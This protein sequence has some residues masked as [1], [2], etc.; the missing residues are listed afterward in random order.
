MVK[1]AL[2]TDA[3]R[4]PDKQV[5]EDA[6]AQRE[7]PFGHLV[8]VCDGMG[9]HIGGREA[10]TA[11]VEAIV[12]TFEQA[13]D[14]EHG[15]VLLDRAISSANDAV[16]RIGVGFAESERPGST[17]VA[18]LV[19]D[20]GTEVA[21]VGD[22]RCYRVHQQGVVQLTRD[23]SMVQQLVNLG[24]LTPEQAKHHPDAN[25]ITRALGTD[26]AERAEL[27]PSPIE[28][29]AGDTFVLCS[30]GLSDVVEPDDILRIVTSAAPEQAAAQ[31][32]DLANERGGPDNITV[33][34][35]RTE[36]AARPQL[37][38]MRP[39]ARTLDDAGERSS[40]GRTLPMPLP[41][42]SGAFSVA[43]GSSGALPPIERQEP[44]RRRNR[45]G[46]F[47]GLLLV[48][49]GVGAG[50]YAYVLHERAEHPKHKATRTLELSPP[51]RTNDEAGVLAPLAASATPTSEAT[52]RPLHV[53]D[54]EAAP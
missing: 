47:V 8:V 16:Y 17:V 48:A 41:S 11:A 24:A 23:H 21:H 5:N 29:A 37:Q 4:D 19:H 35:V 10:S 42:S 1:V 44:P 40:S 53:R 32:V 30:D 7:T 28:H 31:L 52:I 12:R 3:G 6:C 39:V 43:D 51:A 15:R 20:G 45:A 46:T 13:Q 25:R 33:A 54:G 27:M 49:V 38:P 34:V 50:G 14:G 18:I 26:V 9:G 36:S 22:S 2:R